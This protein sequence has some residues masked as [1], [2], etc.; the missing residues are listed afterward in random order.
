MYTVLRNVALLSSK[1]IGLQPLCSQTHTLI[2]QH[3]LYVV[4]PGKIIPL[5]LVS[6][7]ISR[8]ASHERK[9]PKRVSDFMSRVF[10][11]SV[12]FYIMLGLVPSLL[13]I[14]FVNLFI[15][16]AELTDIPEDYEPRHWEYHKHPITRFIAK[17]MCEHPQKLYESSLAELDEVRYTKE[18]VDE[19]RWF[20]KSQLEKGDFRAWY[21]VPVNPTG[22]NRSFERLMKDQE[23]GQLVSR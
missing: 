9:M 22:I 1:H 21:F 14:F 18:L 4:L 17:Y 2:K 23:A 19:E 7:V 20:R 13:L 8:N 10:F 12:H 11:D 5:P 16:P 3:R 6:T 15:G